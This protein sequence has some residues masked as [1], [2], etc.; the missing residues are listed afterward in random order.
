MPGEL[1]SVDVGGQYEATGV[2]R[3]MR[4]PRQ[5]WYALVELKENWEDSW[6]YYPEAELLSG[7][8]HTGSMGGG[9]VTFKIEYSPQVRLAGV[10]ADYVDVEPY[11]LRRWWVRVR[12]LVASDT[13]GDDPVPQTIFVGRVE[14]EVRQIGG[15][16]VENE[17]GVAKS[18]GR[19]TWVALGPLRI[20]QKIDVSTTHGLGDADALVEIGW[21]MGF[22][23]PGVIAERLRGN[24]SAEKYKSQ[25]PDDEGSH[26]FG[27]TEIW[28][29]A[30]MVAY[31]LRRKV[32]TEDA[33]GKPNGPIWTLGGDTKLLEELK[34]R[35]P[36]P[37]TVKAEQ[38][39]VSYTHLTLPT[40]DLV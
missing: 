37:R 26:V 27:G 5:S 2:Q 1:D 10:D 19:Q 22:N 32:Q 33:E 17:D 21:L 31:L 35:V 36:L 30:D 13:P 6:E 20:L 3:I 34:M 14:S 40:S 39:P 7:E 38:L 9:R 24:R 25:S 12:L 16:E 23:R 18:S 29:H 4:P 11:D 8:A 15:A 28:S